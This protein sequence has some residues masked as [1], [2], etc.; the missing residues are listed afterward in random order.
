[1]KATLR[2]IHLCRTANMSWRTC[3]VIKQ[4]QSN[5]VSAKVKL[6]C[7]WLYISF[8]NNVCTGP[9]IRANNWVSYEGSSI[10]DGSITVLTIYM[11]VHLYTHTR[12]YIH[13]YMI[14]RA[15]LTSF[16]GWWCHLVPQIRV[17][18]QGGAW[19][20][21]GTKPPPEPTLTHHQ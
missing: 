6:I 2:H 13:I 11:Y 18:V 20:R 7:R 15:I 14:S 16:L 4:I 17:T 12:T 1:M 21:Y 19:C 9:R 3:V 8:L 10:Q 5:H